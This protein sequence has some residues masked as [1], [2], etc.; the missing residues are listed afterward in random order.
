MTQREARTL[1][2]MS[3]HTLDAEQLGNLRWHL[4]RG[5]V[6]LCG[7]PSRD[8]ELWVLDDKP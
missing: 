3:F 5:T 4:E 7:E 8:T 6:P 2:A 1:L